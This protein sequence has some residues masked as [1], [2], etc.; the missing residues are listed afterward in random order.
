MGHFSELWKKEKGAFYETLCN[1]RIPGKSLNGCDWNLASITKGH[2][3]PNFD[4]GEDE[5]NNERRQTKLP[6]TNVRA[7]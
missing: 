3:S 4:L 2:H 7:A 5:N 1:R 6:I